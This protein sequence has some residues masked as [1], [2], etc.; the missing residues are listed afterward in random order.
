MVCSRKVRAP[1][2]DHML[3]VMHMVPGQPR[4]GVLEVLAEKGG[5]GYTTY[6]LV[7]HI[8]RLQQT[9]RVQVRF[10]ASPASTKFVQSGD[11]CASV[12]LAPRLNAGL[13]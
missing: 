4:H 10:C 12:E 11:S 13:E 5:V 1:P 8:E 6:V 3:L 9:E 7:Q 2:L